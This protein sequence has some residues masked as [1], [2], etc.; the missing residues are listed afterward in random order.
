MT[1]ARLARKLLTIASVLAM[2]TPV[3]VLDEPTT[4]LD[5]RGV[6]RI[7]RGHQ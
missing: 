2:E 3:V 5:S 6:E 4:G 1:W 7:D